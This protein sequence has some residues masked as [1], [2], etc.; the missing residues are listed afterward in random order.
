MYTNDTLAVS[1]SLLQAVLSAL[2][3]ATQLCLILV[4]KVTK[5]VVL[6][7]TEN[8]SP[9]KTQYTVLNSDVSTS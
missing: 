9:Y 2:A 5:D 6:M 4:G 8:T 3:I 1:I 7:K